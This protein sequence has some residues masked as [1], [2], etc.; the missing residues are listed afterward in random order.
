MN[1]IASPRPRAAS[2]ALLGALALVSAL[3]A[4]APAAAQEPAPWRDEGTGCWYLRGGTGLTPRL[5]R[6]GTPDCPGA[7]PALTAPPVAAAPS[8]WAEGLD[9]R[10]T[11]D[12]A[13]AVERLE[14][15]MAALRQAIER[16]AR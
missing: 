4:A 7:P 16:Q 8:R 2:R 9:E 10:A 15:E 12:L 13:R 6:D 14:R 11:R 3:A 1:R 5:R